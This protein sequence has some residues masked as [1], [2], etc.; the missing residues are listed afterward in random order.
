MALEDFRYILCK[1]CTSCCGILAF[2]ITIHIPSCHKLWFRMVAWSPR[3][4]WRLFGCVLFFFKNLSHREELIGL[5]CVS[6]WPGTAF[7][8]FQ[9]PFFV[10]CFILFCINLMKIFPG[11]LCRLMP[12][13]LLRSCRSS[14]FLYRSVRTFVDF[15]TPI[16]SVVVCLPLAESL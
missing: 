5:I 10:Y 9:M 4:W 8:L 16:Y 11:K 1:V 7:A 14:S 13:S 12:V 3:S 15:A 6:S 2:F